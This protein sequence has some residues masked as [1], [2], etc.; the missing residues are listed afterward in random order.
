MKTIGS[1][2]GKIGNPDK[3][4]P[5]LS[6][7]GGFHGNSETTCRC[8]PRASALRIACEAVICIECSVGLGRLLL[9]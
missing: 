1:V 2:I 8:P 6:M 5:V 7:L 4:D 3:L 9:T